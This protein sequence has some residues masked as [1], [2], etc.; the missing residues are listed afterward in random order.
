[1]KNKISLAIIA[2]ISLQFFILVGMYVLSEIP[3]WTG[4]EVKM[5]TV[6]VDPRSMF[7]GN[8]A[9]LTYDMSRVE[10]DFFAEDIKSVRD[11]EVV[12]AVLQKNTDGLYELEKIVLN[13]PDEGVYIKGRTQRGGRTIDTFGIK[14]GIEAFFA[15]KE[16][17]LELERGV[18]RGKAIA[19][20]MVANGK[21]RIKTVTIE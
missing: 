8:Y 11:S 14:Y 10:S 16:K 18:R 7:R 17:A 20:L 15:P 9:I 21:A 2:T 19:T 13:Q 6:P 1:M 3:L 12:Y 4:V 5:K